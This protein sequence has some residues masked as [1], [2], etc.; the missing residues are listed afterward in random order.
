MKVVWGFYTASFNLEGSLTRSGAHRRPIYAISLILFSPPVTLEYNKRCKVNS[1]WIFWSFVTMTKRWPLSDLLLFTWQRALHVS[2]TKCT[3]Y[4]TFYDFLPQITTQA[5]QKQPDYNHTTLSAYTVM[6]LGVWI[7]PWQPVLGTR[8]QP[9]AIARPAAPTHA[10]VHHAASRPEHINIITQ[11]SI[12]SYSSCMAA[13][14][15]AVAGPWC[16]QYRAGSTCFADLAYFYT[17]N[18]KLWHLGP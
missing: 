11:F 2:W 14:A 16:I 1:I 12:L 5:R 3:P 9:P 4:W 15:A 8:L 13:A 18:T 17:A 7:S 6:Y 10:V